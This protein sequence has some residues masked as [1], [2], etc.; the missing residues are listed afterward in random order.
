MVFENQRHRYDPDRS[1]WAA[2]SF[3]TISSG[4]A[5]E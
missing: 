2:L 1:F 5:V 3:F 4:P